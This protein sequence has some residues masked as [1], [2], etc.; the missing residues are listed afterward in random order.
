[1]TIN[2]NIP[3]DLPVCHIPIN[4]DTMKQND[5]LRPDTNNSNIDNDSACRMS[6]NDV[7]TL[8]TML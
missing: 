4:S 5:E 1:M 7:T 3:G 6:Q 8:H 2:S